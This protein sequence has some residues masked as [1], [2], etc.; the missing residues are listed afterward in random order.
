MKTRGTVLNV[1]LADMD[2]ARRE[3]RMFKIGFY[4][5]SG[6][7]RFMPRAIKVGVRQHNRRFDYVGV[8]ELDFQNNPVGHPTPIFI[9]AIKN[10]ESENYV[11]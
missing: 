11:L 6:E 2:D 1:V 5:A 7:Y 10:Y 9:Y 8:Q 4:T 3:G